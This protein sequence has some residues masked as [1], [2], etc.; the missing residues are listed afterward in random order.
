MIFKGLRDT[1]PGIQLSLHTAKRNQIPNLRPLKEYSS[2]K[3]LAG[4][5]IVVQGFSGS[6]VPLNLSSFYNC[7]GL[8]FGS[9]RTCIE[10]DQVPMILADDGYE[11]LREDELAI[12]DIVIYKA[13]ADIAHVGVVVWVPPPTDTIKGAIRVVSKWGE[14]GEYLH[15]LR[16]VP[17]A[18]GDPAEFWTHRRLRHVG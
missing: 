7:V 14:F 9:R 5:R 2:E 12:G 3:L 10:P 16:Q 4:N 6:L 13:D 18:F 1:D 17:S 15:D 8:V 11:R